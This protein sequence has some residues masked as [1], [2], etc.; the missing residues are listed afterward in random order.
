MVTQEMDHQIIGR[1]L[2]R[3]NHNWNGVNV[4]KFSCENSFDD[5]TLY[6]RRHSRA[7]MANRIYSGG[8]NKLLDLKDNDQQESGDEMDSDTKE[9]IIVVSD[10]E[11]EQCGETRKKGWPP[12]TP[13]ELGY[14]G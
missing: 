14:R 7:K 8:D 4:F 5:K 10:D 9:D 2:S 3:G 13:G 6:K 12:K 1:M 11:D